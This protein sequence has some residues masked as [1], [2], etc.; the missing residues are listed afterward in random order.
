[1]M[2]RKTAAVLLSLLLTLAIGLDCYAQTTQEKIDSKKAEQRETKANYQTAQKALESLRSKKND[3]EAYLT[4]LNSQMEELKETLAKLERQYEEKQSELKLVQTEL[5]DAEVLKEQQYEDMKLRI[6]YMYEN[7][8]SSYIEL[9]FSAQSLADFLNKA[10]QI[11]AIA[12]YDREMLEEYEKTIQIIEEKELQVQEEEAAIAQLQS[13]YEEKEE[14]VALLV[15]D[16]YI[17]IREYE[18]EIEDSKSEVSRL[19]SQISSQENELNALIKKQKDEQAAAALARKKAEEEKAARQ[20]AAAQN[21]AAQKTPEKTSEKPPSSSGNSEPSKSQGSSSSGKYLG[22]FKLTAYCACEKCCG[23]SDGI[24]ASG[25]KAT[26]GRTVA[27]GGIP[28][29]TKISINGTVYTVEDRGTVYGHV[30]I[31]K[32]SHQAAR[33]FGLNYAD[34]YRVS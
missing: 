20:A 26:Q 27:M 31:F 14:E 15:E 24:T 3:K 13:E 33:N 4:E 17:Q 19:L 23:K 25:T 34:V 12:E 18:S 1:M 28:L 5:S 16:T 10:D 6:Q 29:G 30:D 32:N 2:G 11:S 8:E 21:G 9:L 7:G 22:R